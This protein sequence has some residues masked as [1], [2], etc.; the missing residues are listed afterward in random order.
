MGILGAF[1]VDLFCNILVLL[2]LVLVLIISIPMLI[3]IGVC[4]TLGWVGELTK[5]LYLWILGR[6]N[7]LIRV[8]K[9]TEDNRNEQ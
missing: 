6:A 4:N 7:N 1:I 2:C 5:E 3:I 8:L 9:E